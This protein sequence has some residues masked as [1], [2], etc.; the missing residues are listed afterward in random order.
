MSHSLCLCSL[1]CLPLPLQVPSWYCMS[2][3]SLYPLNLALLSGTIPIPFFATPWTAARQAPLSSTISQSLLK[4]MSV[5]SMVLSNHLIIC[6][7]R[8]LLPSIL[9]SIRVFSSE[10][11]LGI[12]WPE[13]W[14]LSFSLGIS[15]LDPAASFFLGLLPTHWQVKP[16]PG[17]SVRQ[18]QFLESDCRT[19]DP[20]AHFTSV[21]QFS[22]SVVS[23]SLRP[24]QLQHAGLPV[25]HQLPEST[26][27][28]VH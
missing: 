7:S 24:H 25:H 5:E 28:H 18:S 21:V 15:R 2:C 12:R 17:L 16:D 6:C 9:P 13:Y 26:Q 14:S 11:G 22:R 27:T 8:F 10:S 3:S 4:F 20:R 23:D 1:T 19:R